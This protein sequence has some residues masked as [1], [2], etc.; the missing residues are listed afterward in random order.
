MSDIS[1][2]FT[3]LQLVGLVLIIASPGIVIG[4]VC[5]ALLWQRHRIWGALIAAIIGGFL[6]LAGFQV[7]ADT[8]LSVSLNA[9]EAAG[10]GL[11]HGAPGLIIGAALGFWR[12]RS[13][14]PGGIVAGGIVGLTLWLG[15]WVWITGTI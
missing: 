14:R 4:A 13:N 1:F 8:S 7:W 12:W 5:G 6:S 15:A 11:L 3:P 2:T 9:G 10:L